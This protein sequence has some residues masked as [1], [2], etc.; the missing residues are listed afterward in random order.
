MRSAATTVSRFAGSIRRIARRRPLPV[1]VGFFVVVGF[2]GVA[3]SDNTLPPTAPAVVKAPLHNLSANEGTRIGTDKQ[4]YFLGETVQIEGWE[5]TAGEAVRLQ[6]IHL[7]EN[8]DNTRPEHQPWEIT[9]DQN[10]F[11]LASWEIA[12]D[13]DELGASLKL[14]ADGLTSGTHAEVTFSDLDGTVNL[15]V[16][17][18]RTTAQ[19]AYQ[20]NTTVYPRIRTPK[21]STC[22][23]LT[24]TDPSSDVTK[25]Y[26]ETSDP[27]GTNADPAGMA[28]GTESGRW[29]LVVDQRAAGT[30]DNDTGYG[31]ATSPIFFDVA[32]RVIIGAGTSGTTD[33][34]AP[35]GGDQCVYQTNNIAGI[36]QNAASPTMFVRSFT[37]DSI[38]T[39]VRFDLT[40]ISPAI[41]PGVIVISA[42]VR[43]SVAGTAGTVGSPRT[44][45]IKR[46]D[47]GWTE[48]AIT[49]GTQ[50]GVTGSS[51]TAQMAYSLVAGSG[52]GDPQT[53]VSWPVTADVQG[54][55]DGGTNYGWRISDHGASSTSSGRF[56]TTENTS[57]CAAGVTTCKRTWPVLLIDYIDPPKLVFT[58]S[59][60]T[61][62]V[63]ECSPA[64]RVQSQDFG[65]SPLAVTS[66][67]TVNLS[68]ANLGVG[69][70]GT[71]GAGGFYSNS[72]CTTSTTTTTISTGNT[73][74]ANFYYLA[75]ARGDGTHDIV[76]S[77]TG[78]TP[79]PSQ[80][81][82]IDKA[83]TTLIYTGDRLVLVGNTFNF[84]AVLSSA[85]EP[86]TE[87]KRIIFRIMPSPLTPLVAGSYFSPPAP[88]PYTNTSGVATKSVSTTGW[89]EGIY[90]GRTSFPGDDD[91]EASK[92]DYAI[93]LIEPG[94]AATGGG[95]LAGSKVGGGRANFGF[96]V[97]Q[98]EGSSP[99]AYKGQFLLIKQEGGVPEFRCKGNITLYGE[100]LPSTSPATY[101][102]SGTCDFQLWDP[103]LDGGNGDWYVPA[104]PGYA[105][106]TFTIYFIDN[107]SGKGKYAP[108]PD[109]FGFTIGFGG[110]DDPSFGIA[111]INGGNIDV[112]GTTT[113]PTTG[114]TGGGKKK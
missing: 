111:P 81:E 65:G 91:C 6:V 52:G 88:N 48:G 11:F 5:W 22:Y 60:F 84:S 90:D 19:T 74:S 27:P 92:D 38:R 62:E 99:I 94:G 41:D 112:K 37:N 14:T 45:S 73:E 64:I 35:A 49:W 110:S 63:G 55:L 24:W 10:G 9:A 89:Q 39:Y 66:D 40:T 83:T 95:F 114:S 106:Q 28:V 2:L 107:G 13:S 109:E 86:C 76:A 103:A 17:A 42:K 69:G 70:G 68:T 4:D 82:T 102:A 12:F 25:T 7:D 23:R 53:W 15:F 108:P 59:A 50:P 51:N 18:A 20:W 67:L 46:A 93:S 29:S 72:S 26:L 32:R 104:G 31:S 3:C 57:G 113:A 33:G 47:A 79:N 36:C 43:L 34:A 105:N 71:P 85:W 78:Y 100:L 21:K 98:I 30:C 54:Y 80:T 101:A 87:N 44:Y 97:R 77:A 8:G 75:T 1:V 61:R 56:H 16:D 58:T 96:T